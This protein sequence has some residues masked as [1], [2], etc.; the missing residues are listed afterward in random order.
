MPAP[1]ALRERWCRRRRLRRRRSGTPRRTLRSAP[2]PA[3][4]AGSPEQ[5]C[6]L[7]PAGPTAARAPWQ[8]SRL[9][10]RAPPPAKTPLPDT[11]ASA[12]RAGRAASRRRSNHSLEFVDVAPRQVDVLAA[13]LDRLLDVRAFGELVPGLGRQDV[14]ARLDRLLQLALVVGA[15]FAIGVEAVLLGSAGAVLGVLEAGSD[16]RDRQLGRRV[17]AERRGAP[18]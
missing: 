13:G 16:L 6:L 18:R 4:H 1:T 2:V 3:A 7:A 15:A 10:P 17:E 5:W 14:A 8:P 9:P 11:C 12:S